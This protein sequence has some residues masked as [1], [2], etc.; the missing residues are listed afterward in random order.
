M[1]AELYRYDKLYNVGQFGKQLPL[2][3]IITGKNHPE[4]ISKLYD[5]IARQNYTNYK[6]VH[7]DDHSKR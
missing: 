6:I 5:S 7:I 1:E 2:C 4:G 3:I